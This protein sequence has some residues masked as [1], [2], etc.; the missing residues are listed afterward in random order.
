M[1]LT[2][3]QAKVLYEQVGECLRYIGKL[4]DRM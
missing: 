3:A 1:D 2:C 4:Q